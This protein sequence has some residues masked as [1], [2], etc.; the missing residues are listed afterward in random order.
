MLRGCGT[1]AVEDSGPQPHPSFIGS[2]I[3]LPLGWGDGTVEGAGEDGV[4]TLICR[5]APRFQACSID[6][7]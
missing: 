1:R 5:A 3:K 7:S 4:G 2:H 6:H